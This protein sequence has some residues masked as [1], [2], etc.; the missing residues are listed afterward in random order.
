MDCLRA[1]SLRQK[2]R[3]A[4]PA[5]RSCGSYAVN[6]HGPWDS[7]AGGLRQGLRSTGLCVWALPQEPAGYKSERSV[8]RSEVA[9]YKVTLC[10][11]ACG[12]R[13]P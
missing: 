10:M 6:V 2:V 12:V 11:L 1:G 4:G 8:C 13:G 9:G 5:A 3:T 7:A